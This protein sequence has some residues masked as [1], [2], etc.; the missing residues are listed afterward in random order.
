MIAVLAALIGVL[1]GYYLR[2]ALE[3]RQHLVACRQKATLLTTLARPVIEDLGTELLRLDA[4]AGAA[5][6]HIRQH[7][8]S[9]R[10]LTRRTYGR[11][12]L[13]AASDAS[14]F[15][16]QRVSDSWHIAGRALEEATDL[17]RRLASLSGRPNPLPPLGDSRRC[18]A[19]TRGTL[20]AAL[21]LTKRFA[22]KDTVATILLLTKPD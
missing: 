20:A 13:E 7:Y 8:M 22:A 11:D 16:T 4:L 21:T 3:K 19:S 14:L 12:L 17:L 1:A 18:V 10:A 2:I 5:D 15:G 9:F 6:S